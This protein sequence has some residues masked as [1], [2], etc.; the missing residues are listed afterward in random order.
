MKVAEV[1]PEAL[2]EEN[3]RLKKLLA[4]A[5]LDN[6]AL[7]DL[8]G[9]TADACGAAAGGGAADR[10]ARVQR[11]PRLQA[12]RL[13]PQ[14]RPL[15][16]PAARRCRPARAVAR[17]GGG[18]SAVRL[19]TAGRAARTRG[20]GDEPHGVIAPE[21][22]HNAP[23]HNAQEHCLNESLFGSLAAAWRIIAAWRLDYNARRPHVEPRQPNAQAA[24]VCPSSR[25]ATG[26]RRLSCSP[27]RDYA[28]TVGVRCFSRPLAAM[29]LTGRGE[30][31]LPAEATL[32]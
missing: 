21:A 12:D 2:E 13:R 5:V 32:S 23:W 20:V 3:R 4:E 9:K 27:L 15:P 18:A 28:P 26:A 1:C 22:G 30:G 7:K 19:S 14:H 25:H 8:L 11:A 6:A 17:A 16:V 10:R 24:G 31:L 29:V